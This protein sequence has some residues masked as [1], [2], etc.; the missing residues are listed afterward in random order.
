[1]IPYAHLIQ[2]PADWIR[3][4]RDHDRFLNLIVVIAFLH[5]Y[6]RAWK[7][8]RLENAEGALPATASGYIEATLQDYTIAYEIAADILGNTFAELDKTTADFYAKLESMVEIGAKASKVPVEEYSFTRRQVRSFTKLAPH[9]VKNLMR[10]LTDLEYLDVK[11]APSGSKYFYSL[12]EEK[13]EKGELLGLTK[14][15]ELKSKLS[16]VAPIVAPTTEGGEK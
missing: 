9:I 11:K 5:Q 14:P 13:K 15:E 10:T 7:E 16:V 2:F 6:Q 8:Y 12:A 4:R 1:V 3:T